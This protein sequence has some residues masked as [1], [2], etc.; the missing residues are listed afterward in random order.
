ML[1]VNINVCVFFQF[2]T[3][4]SFRL[5]L[6]SSSSFE[7]MF[8]EIESCTRRTSTITETGGRHGE[9]CLGIESYGI[10]VTTL[11]EVFLRVAGCDFDEIENAQHSKTLGLVDPV[12]SEASDYTQ[13][14]VSYPKLLYEYYKKVLG[15]IFTIM[16]RACSLVFNTVFS[17]ISFLSIQ[18]CSPNRITRSTFWVHFRAL[19][20]KRAISARRDRRTIVFQLLIP[21]LFLF[22]GLLLVKLKPHPDQ[23]SITFTTSEFNPVLQG[24]GGGGPIPF[25]LSWPIAELV[26]FFVWLKFKNI[27]LPDFE[28]ASIFP[29][30]ALTVP[31]FELLFGSHA[32]AFSESILLHCRLDNIYK[33]GGFR[34][35]NQDHISSLIQTGH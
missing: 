3:E 13:I 15:I 32:N 8:Q 30:K 23:Q 14:K 2:G 31:G 18:C 29:L 26:C 5:P 4:I 25:N 9:S 27:V 11:E 21:A 33:G 1:I 17:F 22:L 20:I 35:L 10:S 19:L 6:A 12:V 16:G 34:K 7:S 28:Y 24:D